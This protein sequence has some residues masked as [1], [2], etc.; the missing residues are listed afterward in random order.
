MSCRPHDITEIQ[1]RIVSIF[2][3]NIMRQKTNIGTR[4]PSPTSWEVWIAATRPHTLTASIAPCLV[5]YA[6]TTA[7]TSLFGPHNNGNHHGLFV[8]W[9]IFCVTVQ[10]GTN[11]HNDYADFVQ[12]ADDKDKRIGPPRVTAQGWW[13]PSQ[14]CRA[15]TFFLSLTFLSGVYL[16][17]LTE[18]L[19]NPV[20]W[21]LILSSI[22]NAF[23]YTGGPYPLGYLGISNF[24]LAYTGLA[25]LFVLLYFGYVATLM[26]P[27]LLYCQN[28]TADLPYKSL[29]TFHV[30][31]ATSVGW[32][33]MKILIVNN[34]R[35]RKSDALVQKRTTAVRFG[36]TFGL[37]EYFVCDVIA[38]GAYLSEVVWNDV[39]PVEGT[40]VRWSSFLPF[41]T[42]PLAMKEFYHVCRKEDAELNAHVGGAAKVQFLFCLLL[43]IA[44]FM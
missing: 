1:S 18:Q 26:V 13:T 33:A 17:Y 34:L 36:R 3:P 31:R 38:Y 27:Y 30:C 42:L 15:A 6:S 4:R 44:T 19:A 28:S 25:D 12:G 21:F 23:A 41:L 7:T 29:W 35:D 22:F 39:P 14:T 8:L 5:S 40:Q 10:I 9:T 37:V 43:T 2:F 32:L 11:L 16:A 24:S 20:V